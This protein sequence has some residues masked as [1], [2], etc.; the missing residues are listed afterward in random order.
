[1]ASSDATQLVRSF[2]V[3]HPVGSTD[4]RTLRAA[5]FDAGLAFPH[6]RVGLGGLGLDPSTYPQVEALFQDAGAADFTDR[7]VIGLGMAAP[8][9]HDHGTPTQQALL[10]PLFSGEHIWCQLFSEPGAGSDLANLSTRAVADGNGWVVNGQK[11][12]TTLA[13]QARWGLLLARSDPDAPKH[14]GLTYFILDMQA[15]GVEVRPLRQMTGEAEFNECYFTNVLLGPDDVIGQAGAGWHVAMTTLANERVS[16]GT[17]T[18][19]SGSR[20]IDVAVR[21]YQEA[22][23]HGRA[24]PAHRHRLMEL[25]VRAEVAELTNQRAQSGAQRVPGP[26]GSVNKLAMA[27]LNKATF[28]LVVNLAGAEGMLIDNYDEIRP[29]VASVHGGADLRKAF[30]RTRANSIEG[31]TSEIMRTI[32]GERVLGLPPEPRTD[33]GTPWNETRRA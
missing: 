10:R 8:T 20:P 24:L 17:S 32:L 16:L 25:W 30:L 5:R 1:V 14:A 4:E 11:V 22:V 29:A 19:S 18:A 12:W 33:R 31:G 21:T 26:E 15:E 27:E 13:H 7:N 3:Q 28:E 6:F 2:L 9:L 23:V